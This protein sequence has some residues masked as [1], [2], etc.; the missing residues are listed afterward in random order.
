MKDERWEEI[1][2]SARH[3]IASR[4]VSWGQMGAVLFCVHSLY[5]WFDDKFLYLNEI[6]PPHMEN[7]AFFP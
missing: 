2:S 6:D 7:K 4:F 1:A 5:T 3:S